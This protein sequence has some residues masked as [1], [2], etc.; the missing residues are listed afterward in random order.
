MIRSEKAVIKRSSCSDART[1]FR[2]SPC[3]SSCP[4]TT[5]PPVASAIKRPMRRILMLSTSD[6]LATADSPTTATIIV[7][8]S[9]TS[10]ASSCSMIMGVIRFFRSLLVNNNGFTVK[11]P[12]KV[13]LNRRFIR[14]K[15]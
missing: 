4:A 1:A 11:P 10:T 15:K 3:P 12:S 2:L 9:P 14:L 8:A 6:T 5:A 13:T 7:S